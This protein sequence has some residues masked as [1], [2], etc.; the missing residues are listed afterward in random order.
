MIVGRFASK[1]VFLIWSVSLNNKGVSDFV[2]ASQ[3]I[4]KWIFSSTFTG[5][6]QNALKSWDSVTF[7]KKITYLQNYFRK[8]EK[9]LDPNEFLIVNKLIIANINF[10]IGVLKI[11]VE[12]INRKPATV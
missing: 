7:I 6:P 12:V 4:M 3:L 11:L 10:M 2:R 8:F 1:Q 5:L 9:L